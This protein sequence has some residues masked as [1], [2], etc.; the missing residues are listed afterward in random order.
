MVGSLAARILDNPAAADSLL[1]ANGVD[2]QRL[3]S[4][5]YDIASDPEARAEYLEALNR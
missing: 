3:D 4:V 1:A 5:M 2:V